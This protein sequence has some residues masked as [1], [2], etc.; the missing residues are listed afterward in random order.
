MLIRLHALLFAL[1]FFSMSSTN[2]VSVASPESAEAKR[3]RRLQ[4][5]RERAR[6]ASETTEQRFSRRMI[7]DRARREAQSVEQRR[8]E[9]ERESSLCV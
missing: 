2:D 1:F 4:I 6:L 9:R 5:R 8:R 3:V 7:R